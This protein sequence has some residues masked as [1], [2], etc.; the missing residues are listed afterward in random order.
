MKQALGKS[1]QMPAFSLKSK[2]AVPKL[3]FWN[4]LKKLQTIRKKKK[5]QGAF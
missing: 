5:S 3:Q 4:G 2:A 1:G